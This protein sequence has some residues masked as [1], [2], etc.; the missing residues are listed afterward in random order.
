MKVEQKHA[1]ILRECLA[2]THKSVPPNLQFAIV[3]ALSEYAKGVED[4]CEHP[5]VARVAALGILR[6]L[7]C[8]QDIVEQPTTK[9]NK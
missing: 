9:E 5:E 1:R 7:D 2:R 8:C 6:C 4:Y 3:Q